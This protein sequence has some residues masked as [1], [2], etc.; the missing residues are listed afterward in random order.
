MGMEMYFD[1]A[2]NVMEG[3]NLGELQTC[4]EYKGAENTTIKMHSSACEGGSTPAK[5]EI[6]STGSTVLDGI[7]ADLSEADKGKVTSSC[8][9]TYR[10]AV[11]KAAGGKTTTIESSTGTGNLA[12]A[13]RRRLSSRRL[14]VVTE[15]ITVTSTEVPTAD[16]STVK[17]SLDDATKAGGDLS[18]DK[19][20]AEMVTAIKAEVT[21]L[22]NI[23]ATPAVVVSEP[24]IPVKTPGS[25]GDG[26]ST[27]S[28]VTE[29]LAY[30]AGLAL[31]ASL[32]M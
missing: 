10:A 11:Q 21:T 4:K 15:V 31:L 23:T 32:L 19:L 12:P 18:S 16:A 1:A 6:L 29:S 26:G 25:G 22:G 28:A 14:A 13:T 7:P 20:G 27:S 30:G 8:S 5:M 17:S 3:T 2:C 9:E 24:S